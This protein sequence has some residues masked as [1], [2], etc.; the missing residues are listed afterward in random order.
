MAPRA[1]LVLLTLLLLL[2]GG[3]AAQERAAPL[4][5]AP[6]ERTLQRARL[7]LRLRENQEAARVE[8]AARDWTARLLTLGTEQEGP[9]DHAPPPLLPHERLRLEAELATLEARLLARAAERTLLLTGGG[10]AQDPARRLLPGD[11]PQPWLGAASLD[12]AALARRLKE[13]ARR[14]PLRALVREHAL[15]QARLDGLEARVLPVHEV[16][17]AAALAG[18]VDGQVPLGDVLAVREALTGGQLEVVALRVRRELQ[19]HLLAA[20]LECSAE[21]VVAPA[22]RPGPPRA[23]AAP[24]PRPLRVAPAP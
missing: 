6:A 19:V 11:P 17:L 13:P 7:L 12:E 18:L 24:A 3:A 15:L 5:L 20:L 9:G 14:A 16:A 23:A 2:P 4:P 22:P 1:P 21:A 8:E 10:L